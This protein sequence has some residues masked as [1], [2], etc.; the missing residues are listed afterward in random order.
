MTYEDIKIE[1]KEQNLQEKFCSL[2]EAIIDPK[3]LKLVKESDK[4]HSTAGLIRILMRSLKP[5]SEEW[6]EWLKVLIFFMSPI[7]ARKP[8]N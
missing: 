1:L 8:L 6:H 4:I 5:A 3:L 7:F 2:F